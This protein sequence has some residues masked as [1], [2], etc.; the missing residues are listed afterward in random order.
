[1]FFLAFLPLFVSPNVS[2]PMF[3]MLILSA[4]FMAM[5]LTIFIIYG[6]AANYVRTYIVNSPK[7]INGLQK[8]FA[9]VFA[10]LGI[11]LAMTEQ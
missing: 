10:A 2:S 11:K 8:T 9:V 3:Q 6:L 5:T 1:M 4:V 7:A